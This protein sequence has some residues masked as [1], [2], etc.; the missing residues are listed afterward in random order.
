M[1]RE[2]IDLNLSRLI[3]D[4]IVVFRNY[5]YYLYASLQSSSNDYRGKQSGT[6]APKKH[7][8]RMEAH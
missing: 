3:L 4:Y 7:P 6:F 8:A 1:C 5:C 2:I